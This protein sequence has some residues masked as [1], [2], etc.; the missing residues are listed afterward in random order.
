[1]SVPALDGATLQASVNYMAVRE[2]YAP[3]KATKETDMYDAKTFEVRAVPATA[4]PGLCPG[5]TVLVTDRQ[6]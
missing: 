4:L 1:M 3:W 2:S 5:M 6:K